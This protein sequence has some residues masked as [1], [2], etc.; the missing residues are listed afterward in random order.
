MS[1][2]EKQPDKGGAE[3]K[4]DSGSTRTKLVK[5]FTGRWV[6]AIIVV[7]VAVHTVGFLYVSARPKQAPEP[8]RPEIS[9][10]SFKFISGTAVP[11][12]VQNAAFDLHV[13]MLNPADAQARDRFTAVKFRLQ[14][15]IEELLR[16]AHSSDFDDPVLADLKRQL[17]V[18][19]NETLGIKAI[20]DVIITNL[21]LERSAIATQPA[22]QTAEKAAP[23]PK[24]AG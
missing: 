8:P 13:S 10:G 20:S 7:S 1:T 19:V 5:F 17:Q 22:S 9:L 2:P 14:Q 6:V 11:G 12:G 24:S 16:R 4:A 3:A 23:E 18:L 15:N 21:S